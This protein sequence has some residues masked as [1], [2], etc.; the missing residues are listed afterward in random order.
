M[1]QTHIHLVGFLWTSI[2][3]DANTLTWKTHNKH[4]TQTSMSMSRFE[5]IILARKRPQ[6]DTLESA[7]TRIGYNNLLTGIRCMQWYNRDIQFIRWKQM[8]F[9]LQPLLSVT[10]CVLVQELL[11][12]EVLM[13]KYR[14]NL[15][16]TVHAIMTAEYRL[17]YYE[18][19]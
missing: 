2:R 7:A 9:V 14:V 16:R 12:Q 15:R 6:T 4:K 19:I 1:T 11:H 18:I 5:P 3:P 8:I 13:R 17:W 10:T